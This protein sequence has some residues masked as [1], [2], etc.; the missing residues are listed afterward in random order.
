[1]ISVIQR[2][3]SGSVSVDGSV[4]SSINKG[5]LVLAGIEKGDTFADLE[6]SAKKITELRIFE[7]DAEKMNLSVIDV[8]G[9]ILAV[10]QFTLL[11]NVQKGRRPGFDNAMSPEIA[12]TMFDDFVKM[13]SK[14]ISTVKTGSF[15]AHME[16]S[17]INDGPVT[18]V[19]DSRKRV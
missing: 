1:M 10:S 8:G 4:I 17:L 12:K 15:G 6:Y 7:D 16:V 9:E 13:L 11:G 14:A 2:V 3:K 5:L 18:F 19:I